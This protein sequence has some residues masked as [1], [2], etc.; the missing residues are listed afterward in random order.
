MSQLYHLNVNDFDELTM[1]L[2]AAVVDDA[3]YSE[4]ATDNGSDYANDV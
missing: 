4:D 2:S 3:Y 1:L